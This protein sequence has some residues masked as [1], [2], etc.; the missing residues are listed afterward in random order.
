MATIQLG[1]TESA[2]TGS[3]GDSDQ[4][5]TI[6]SVGGTDTLTATESGTC[7]KIF[8]YVTDIGSGSNTMHVGIY[9]DNSGTP[10]N[11]IG[12]GTFNGTYS[13]G[14]NEISISSTAITSGNIYY[15]VVLAIA[16]SAR[17]ATYNISGYSGNRR[18]NITTIPDPYGADSATAYANLIYLEYEGAATG[19]TLDADAG[20]YNITGSDVSTPITRLLSAAVGAYSLTGADTGITLDRILSGESGAFVLTGSDVE[21]TISLDKKLDAESG[22]YNLT[23]SEVNIVKDAILNAETGAFN[24]TGSEVD[25]L[26]Q[27]VL[28]AESGAYS[29]TGADVDIKK[30]SVLNAESGSFILTGS[31]VSI[32]WS[33]AAVIQ[34]PITISMVLTVPNLTMDMSVPSITM[35]MKA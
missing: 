11:L 15:P 24:L 23:G 1:C 12:S 31:D 14:W 7:T 32:I 10:N 8:V 33:G 4:A 30:S 22:A 16:D 13:V 19:L 5:H 21:I 20:A 29:L 25:I 34:P 27:V 2:F 3:Y 6:L 9:D 17:I 18:L 28:S 35:E 26:K